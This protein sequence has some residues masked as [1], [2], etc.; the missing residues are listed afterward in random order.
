MRKDNKTI[1]VTFRFWTNN[2][3]VKKDG[4]PAKAVWNSGVAHLEANKERE[5]KG[6]VII[7]NDVNDAV[8]VIRTLFKRNKILLVDS[9][10]RQTK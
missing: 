7:V 4:L 9:C 10:R 8:N 5:I 6:D 1:A 2:L 3:E